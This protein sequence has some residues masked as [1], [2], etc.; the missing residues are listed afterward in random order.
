VGGNTAEDDFSTAGGGKEARLHVTIGS[1]NMEADED[2]DGGS[3]CLMI[4]QEV[5]GAL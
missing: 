1:G 5:Y 3:D 2:E 4:N